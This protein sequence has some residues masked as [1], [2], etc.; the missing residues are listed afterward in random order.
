MMRQNS[1]DRVRSAS[2]AVSG[3]GVDSQSTML[4]S[5]RRQQFDTVTSSV[6][7]G[8][9]TAVVGQKASSTVQQTSTSEPDGGSARHRRASEWAT[10]L[11]SEL[12][13]KGG[14]GAAGGGISIGGESPEECRR[15]ELHQLRPWRLKDECKRKKLEV[16]RE[17]K[18]SKERLVELLIQ[19]EFYRPPATTPIAAGTV[20]SK[21]AEPAE[22]KASQGSDTATLAQSSASA[23]N[24]SM[25]AL[26]DEGGAEAIWANLKI[27][28]L[29]LAAV[30]ATIDGGKK[31]TSIK[32]FHSYLSYR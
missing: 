26:A 30:F 9:K 1:A 27:K 15:A 6:G 18:V 29:K 7:R 28:A 14:T 16:P 3:G 5:Q 25:S 23:N 17:G 12:Q 21:T 2:V 19:F 4:L 10:S 13:R 31:V 32:L 11:S 22:G 24:G 20:T 8:G